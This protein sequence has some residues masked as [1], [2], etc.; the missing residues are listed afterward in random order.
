M[1]H[2]E[3]SALEHF[4]AT[5]YVDGDARER[6]L[7]AP[8]AEAARAGL[9]KEQCQALEKIDRVGLEMAARSFGHKRVSKEI[10]A[11]SDLHGWR[12]VRQAFLRVRIFGFFLRERNNL[13]HR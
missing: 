2:N 13:L 5:L 9:S 8:G 10:A 3:T 4:L 1:S 12:R 6:F 7:A 11:A